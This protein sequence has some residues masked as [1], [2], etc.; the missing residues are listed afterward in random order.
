M[1]DQG[2]TLSK[3]EQK[4]K[5]Q[6][7]IKVEELAKEGYEKSDLT[8]GVVKANILAVII[9]IPVIILM[10]VI[11]LAV[12]PPQS[13]LGGRLNLAFAPLIIFPSFIL[14]TVLHEL[15][16]GATWAIFAKEHFKSISFGV[17]WAM[18][19]PYCTCNELLKKWQYII[20][21]IM[22][23]IFVGFLPAVFAILYHNPTLLFIS[24]IMVA[25]GGCDAI[26]AAKLLMY[27]PKSIECMY[28][29]HP[30][31]CGMVVFE[32]K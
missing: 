28:M 22:P 32:K 17:I 24:M 19:T 12:N 18:L 15:I 10:V 23:T 16:H 8:I 21:A 29:D 30:Y 11:Y 9:A 6:F 13:M 26:I 3:A 14:L 27:R 2:R 31:E 7:D 4:R 20:G 1:K 5:E 25:G